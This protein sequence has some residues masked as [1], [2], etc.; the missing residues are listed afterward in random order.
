MQSMS[1]VGSKI[2]GTIALNKKQPLGLRKRLISGILWNLVAMI[3][4]RGSTL[5]A[6]I[7]VAR[8]LGTSKYGELSIIQSTIG[9]FGTFA[10]MGLGVTCTKYIAELKLND[11]ARAGRIIAL[12]HMV[13]WIS[14]GILSLA[15]IGLAPWLAVNTL[16]NPDL[17]HGLQLAA[18][19]LL[20]STITGLQGGTLAG[21]EAFRELARIGV[22][23]GLC[24]FPLIL[25]CVYCGGVEGAV[26]GMGLSNLIG[27]FLNLRAIKLLTSNASIQTCFRSAW[28]ERSVLKLT[29]I[30]SMLTGVMVG[31]VVWYGN[32]LI[33]SESGGYAQLGIFNA[34]NQWKILLTYIPAVIGRVLL[35]MLSATVK[36]QNI[37]LETFNILGNWLLVTTIAMIPIAIPESI[38]FF[39][40]TE[41]IGQDFNLCLSL[42][43]LVSIILAYK[44]GIA[45]KLI[46]TNL[47]W[48][49]IFSNFLW[50]IIFLVCVYCFRSKG[51]TGL[52]FSFITSYI[53]NTVI[54]IPFYIRRKVVS[55][56]LI[57]SKHI[58]IAWVSIISVFGISYSIDP[59]YLR[60]LGLITA[61]L[62]IGATIRSFARKSLV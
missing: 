6:T 7:I 46:T 8:V 1:T 32:A 35:P 23:Q 5:V 3:A 42:M 52:A 62:V 38:S 48:W 9:M 33:V 22:I 60:V 39:Y 15:L 20:F 27:Y 21:F 26:I 17:S 59:L 57:I 51:A 24:A 30:P 18:L 31:P 58:L 4:S 53:I 43:M 11:P 56:D 47:L 14:A 28:Q 61:S 13:G 54:F 45:R 50:S 19:L 44:E 40:G 10:G 41:Y 37:R 36:S 49:G 12:T 16:A 55:K 29:A 25:A 34:V 2:T